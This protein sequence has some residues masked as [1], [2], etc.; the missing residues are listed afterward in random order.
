VE[1]ASHLAAAREWDSLARF[2]LRR[3]GGL[4]LGAGTP[5]VLDPLRLVP[6][7]AVTLG[8]EL[9]C[10]AA[11][12]CCAEHDW[13]GVRAHVAR[14][15]EL[16]GDLPER[17]AEIT[18]A[19]L[20]TLESV[21]AW[22]ECDPGLQVA[23]ASTALDRL[24]RVTAEE[25]PALAEYR[26]TA[27]L[28]LVVGKLWS[29]SRDEAGDLATRALGAPSPEHMHAHVVQLHSCLSV[30]RAL[31][32]RLREAAAEAGAATGT[33]EAAGWLA[34]PQPAMAMLGTA[35]VHLQ[36]DEPDRCSMAIER[37]RSCTGAPGDR[38]TDAALGLVRAD[39]A[40]S[41]AAPQRAESM[42]GAQPEHVTGADA[43]GLLADWSRRVASEQHLAEGS[44]DTAATPQWSGTEGPPDPY[45]AVLDARA[46]MAA[47]RARDCL[48]ILAPLREVPPRELIPSVEMLLLSA[49]AHDRLRHDAE[50]LSALGRALDLAGPEEIARP[51]VLA[52]PRARTL[53]E[54]Y[55]QTHVGRGAFASVLLGKLGATAVP[56]AEPRLLEPLTNRERSVLLLLPTMMS[57][58]EIAD[59]LFVSVNT[60][61]VHLKSLYRKLGVNNRRQAV[62][63]ARELGV[64]ADVESSVPA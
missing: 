47:N 14:A 60:V 33:A 61:K 3:A 58:V 43:P 55:R 6:G 27:T 57:N 39:L 22:G 24:G 34:P 37:G 46:A 42:H 28:V 25:V 23:T 53:L 31:Q 11:V 21:A 13:P 38:L 63:R 56:H 45:D 26:S 40:L 59:E 10:A 16:L 15:R 12:G 9:S 7:E 32:G 49:L 5:A 44:G 50:A 41:R 36:R 17:Q 20:V 62:L 48:E 4:L 64:M 29:G 1:A 54:R 51:F 52:G 30:V 8:P 35:L 18:D 19:V 2:V